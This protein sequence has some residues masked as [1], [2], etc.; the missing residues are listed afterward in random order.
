MSDQIKIP[1]PA[2]GYTDLIDEALLAKAAAPSDRKFFPLRPSAA[3]YCSRRLAFDLMQ[4]R[5]HATYEKEVRKPETLR[6]L[7]LGSPIEWHSIR[8]FELIGSQKI[9]PVSVRYKQNTVTL[10]RLEPTELGLPAE[11]IEGSLD[12]AVVATDSGGIGDVKSKK[13]KF[14]AAYKSDWDEALEEFSQMK[15]LHQISDTSFYAADLPAFLEELNDPFFADNFY[16]VNTYLCTEW[17]KER[18]FDHGFIYRYNK[19]TSRHLEIRFAPSPE[20]F[21]AVQDKFNK[22]NQA[23]AKKD[24]ESIRC[25]YVMGS[26]RCAFCPYKDKC[27]GGDALQAFFNNFPK[28]RWPTKLGDVEGGDELI[29]MFEKYEAAL[30]AADQGKKIEQEI[31]KKLVA[32]NISKVRLPNNHIYEVKKLTYEVKL[33]RTKV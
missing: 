17:A 29:E 31:I 15:T 27:W 20:M 21:K 10:F 9:E 25:D 16:Q 13:E 5:G 1:G 32:A 2:K 30:E 7:D 18:G 23:V 11:L 12:L 33:K 4:Y 28:K 26:A 19:N 6:L 3:G 14:S 8:N 24:P 22:V